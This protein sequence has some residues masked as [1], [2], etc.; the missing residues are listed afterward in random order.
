MVGPASWSLRGVDARADLIVDGAD[1]A[2]EVAV[3]I[4]DGRGGL[5]AVDVK[6]G[7]L[8]FQE[9]LRGDGD[10]V[11]RLETLPLSLL[12][13]VPEQ[14]L[15]S[16]PLS[17]RP[18]GVRGRIAATLSIKGTALDPVVE[19]SL[20]TQNVVVTA[21]PD[22]PMDGTV[23]AHYDGT[24]ARMVVSVRRATALLLSAVADLHASAKDVVR[25]R[26]LPAQ[27]GGALRA[28]LAGFPLGAVG[29][30]SDTQVVG[31]VSGDVDVTGLHEDAKAAVRLTLDRLRVGKAAFTNGVAVA[32]LDGKALT[33][34]LRLED[35]KGFLD[36]SASMG[37][38]WG[39]V[40]V[41]VSDGTGLRATL[42][43]KHFPAAAAA[44][45]VS[46]AL[47]ELSGWID[48]DA[49]VQL[50]PRQKPHMSGSVSFTDGVIQAPALGEEFHSV[51][52]KVTLDADGLVK[53]EDVEA[54][55]LSGRLTASGSAHL[56]GTTLVSAD[57]ALD[58]PKNDAIPLDIQGSNL[59]TAYGNVTVK[60][61]GTP[62]GK[63]L[64]IAVLVPHAHVDLPSGSLPRSPQ[65]LADAPSLHMGTYV[66]ADRFLVLPVDGAPVTLVAERNLAT[67]P[68]L[69]AGRAG[70][71]LL[72]ES[73]TGKVQPQKQAPPAMQIDATVHVADLQV[74]RGQ[75]VAVNL[76][77]DLTA[78]VA[79][80]TTVRGKIDLKSGKLTL[81]SKAFAIEKGTIS[82]VGDDPSNPEV[83]VT[84]GWTAPDGT[85]VLAD[86]VG[87]A[88]T[89]KVTLRSE[90]GRPKNEIVQLI[91]FG[92]ADGS[93]ATP[94]ASKSP[95]TGTQAGTA[96]GG[97]ATEGISKGLDQLTGIDV[98]AKVDT[99]DASN[100]RADV[101]IQI[102][103]D[104]SL[105]LA[106][107][108]VQPPPGDNPTSSTRRSTGG[109]SATGRSRRRSETQGAR[110]PT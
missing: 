75:Q 9:I 24:D 26:G 96:V 36:A 95:D 40:L 34:K 66:S 13:D 44:P 73:A 20:T 97:L 62:D 39:T 1:G 90:P 72:V 88:K 42:A 15:S 108:I 52:A 16:L 107:V 69:P 106:Y 105:Q 48:A 85:K 29:L 23:T 79:A 61:T 82:F 38:T 99:S 41:P 65:A 6:T 49:T 93:E 77:G 94:Y 8:P 28:K 21:A 86:Y 22:L 83:S 31:F 71:P 17:I 103:N 64:K 63:T 81:Q 76:A 46:G 51:K 35:P 53:L 91:L 25:A 32:T 59:G 57:L 33:A 14:E 11:G 3:R 101:E 19:L 56:D 4:V 98:T 100:P 5:A 104:I 18:D 45:F 74:L 7:P 12:V 80:A 60:A 89:G 43:A 109:S 70:A 2:G 68:A 78:K 54:R 87:P 92:T 58:I 102:A 67:P 55:G 84:A 10:I 27:W 110:S 47:T 37:M 50:V 30:L